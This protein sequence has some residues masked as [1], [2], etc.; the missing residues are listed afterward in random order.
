[1]DKEE[2]KMHLLV[3]LFVSTCITLIIM[4][5][6]ILLD[7]FRH[8]DIRFAMSTH[9]MDESEFVYDGLDFKSYHRTLNR[10]DILI[11][12]VYQHQIP[13]IT[14]RI[15][16][17]YVN[18]TFSLMMRDR[19]GLSVSVFSDC[20]YRGG[21]G[22]TM[23][24]FPRDEYW[25]DFEVFDGGEIMRYIDEYLPY[26]WYDIEVIRDYPNLMMTAY[27]DGEKLYERSIEIL[28]N[29]TGGCL[30]MK[31]MPNREMRTGSVYLKD[32]KVTAI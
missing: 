27:K 8:D 21:G 14:T 7:I 28:T 15:D 10:S 9:L 1:M 19:T 6:I 25:G 11:M 20:S 4:P 18:V 29:T 5:S 22:Q 17:D 30:F 12:P 23:L 26:E 24:F 32:I 3:V 13:A 31:T 16:G 2:I